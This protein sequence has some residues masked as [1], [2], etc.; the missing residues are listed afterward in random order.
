M[1]T[2]PSVAIQLE[3]GRGFC[4]HGLHLDKKPFGSKVIPAP[5]RP[6]DKWLKNARS[7]L[8]SKNE[9]SCV[10]RFK[11]TRVSNRWKR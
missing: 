3:H 11:Q 7:V 5:K 2:Q 10:N 4:W 8:D 9:L 1:Q 6:Y